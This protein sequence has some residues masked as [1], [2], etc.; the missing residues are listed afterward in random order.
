[1][2]PKKFA[3]PMKFFVIDFSNQ[4]NYPILNTIVVIKE[5]V[6]VVNFFVLSFFGNLLFVL[7]FTVIIFIIVSPITKLDYGTVSVLL[8]T[9]F[10]FYKMCYPFGIAIKW[11]VNMINLS[12][13]RFLKIEVFFISSHNS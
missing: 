11:F 6:L 5:K 13:L 4:S 7:K 8:P 1:M 3:L 10:T 9:L 2:C 12:E